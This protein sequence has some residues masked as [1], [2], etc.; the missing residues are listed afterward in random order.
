MQSNTN[1]VS[2]QAA[3]NAPKKRQ[4]RSPAYPFISIRTALERAETFRVAEGGRPR[5]HSPVASA[6]MAWGLRLKTGD[7]KQTIAALGHYGLF[8]FQG[9]GENR[10][11]RLTDAA[12]QILLDKQPVSP[13]RDALVRKAALTPRIHSEL[14]QKWQSALPSDATL[15]TYLVRDRGF[16]E[17]GARD[18]MTEYKDTIAFTKLGQPGAIPPSN[19]EEEG[20]DPVLPGIAEVGDLVQVEING[21]LQFKDPKRVRAVQEY[22]GKPYAFV[23]GEVTGFSMDQ[24]HVVE[25]GGGGGGPRDNGKLAPTLPLESSWHEERLIDDTGD[26]VL[27]RYKG[28][29]SVERY[30]FIRDYLDFKVQRLVNRGKKAD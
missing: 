25:K 23:E 8:E 15:E 12:L 6:A 22:E 1:P 24:L 20:E 11:V 2:N 26:E 14:W 18:L 13:E 27:V 19:D 4:G 3:P 7:T 16:S 21:T 10:K 30:E 5:H 29:P 28:E 9:E 17:T